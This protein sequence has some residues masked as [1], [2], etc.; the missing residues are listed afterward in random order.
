MVTGECEVMTWL[1]IVICMIITRFG[2]RNNQE[3]MHEKENEEGYTR[4]G[5]KEDGSWWKPEK[6]V[7]VKENKEI[8]GFQ[9]GKK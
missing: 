8:K 2:E 4:K 5:G 1:V 9:R 3:I 7:N 6:R